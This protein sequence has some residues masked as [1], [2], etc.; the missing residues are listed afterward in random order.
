MAEFWNENEQ[1]NQAPKQPDIVETASEGLTQ[2]ADAQA[3]QAAVEAVMRTDRGS[4]LSGEAQDTDSAAPESAQTNN[5]QAYAGQSEA[6]PH[7]AQTNTAQAYAAQAGSGQTT[8]G[9]QN[10]Q[11]N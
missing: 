8:G 1:G 10:A 4:G 6:V 11:Q 5:T 7:V 9:A 3:A 2:E